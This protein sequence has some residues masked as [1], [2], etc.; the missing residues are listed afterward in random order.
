MRG[1]WARH[2]DKASSADLLLDRTD[3]GM[4]P[5][6][7]TLAER[8][9][10]REER[11]RAEREDRNRERLA[12]RAAIAAKAAGVSVTS[13]DAA[14]KNTTQ[15]A[16][17]QNSQGQTPVINTEP[18]KVVIR[19]I[20]ASED[21]VNVWL[22]KAM[23]PEGIG[24]E[25][26]YETGDG[27]TLAYA[28]AHSEPDEIRTPRVG[29]GARFSRH[30]A[31]ASDTVSNTKLAETLRRAN[32]QELRELQHISAVQGVAEKLASGI[33]H[34]ITMKVSPSTAAP[35]DNNNEPAKKPPTALELWENPEKA[36]PDP[37][38]RS[39]SI[40]PKKKI[41]PSIPISTHNTLQDQEVPTQKAQHTEYQSNQRYFP[42]SRRPVFQK[43]ITERPVFKRPI[44]SQPLPLR[45]TFS[46]TPR[47]PNAFINTTKTSRN[48]TSEV[49]PTHNTVLE[50]PTEIEPSN[51]EQ[52]ETPT[53]PATPNPP[54]PQHK[55][56]ETQRSISPSTHTNET[57]NPIT[58]V[59]SKRPPP[60]PPCT[61]GTSKQAFPVKKRKTRS[62]Q[63]NIKKD[64][65]PTELRP[66]GTQR[67]KSNPPP[68]SESSPGSGSL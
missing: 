60:G 35:S 38:S 36:Q 44:H 40:A 31:P 33:Q 64:H 34:T 49:K 46:I 11:L 65:R 53:I 51:S 25:G 54:T 19:G 52:L 50:R 58:L 26:A 39:A 68:T 62:R 9:K 59:G 10:E 30:L 28:I 21:L 3:A 4:A 41:A 13:G 7:G 12:K 45:N 24:D 67:P 23:G 56:I 1:T 16:V 27:S 57:P 8:K 63:K 55:P 17:A 47:S 18:S 37:D 29:L 43:S 66:G 48:V 20:D 14:T 22:K 42:Q 5:L 2:L 6:P 32:K 61:T 15:S